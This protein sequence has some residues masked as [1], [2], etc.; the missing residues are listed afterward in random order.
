MASFTMG[1]PEVLESA[2][3]TAPMSS[4]INQ[5]LLSSSLTMSVMPLMHT[6]DNDGF[7]T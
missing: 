6:A 5:A 7:S 2:G 4:R 3:T 1:V